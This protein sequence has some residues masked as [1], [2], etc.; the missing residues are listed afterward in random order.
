MSHSFF[1]QLHRSFGPKPSG[2]DQTDFVRQKL[3]AMASRFLM[4]PPEDKPAIRVG[5]VGGGFAGLAAGSYL[6]EMF[7][8]CPVES[9][10][11]I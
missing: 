5:I 9:L 2:R 6:S 1:A 8:R 10:L 11:L 3:S 4:S 7:V